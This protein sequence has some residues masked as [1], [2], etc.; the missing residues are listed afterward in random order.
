M[1]ASVL[2]AVEAG[3]PHPCAPLDIAK[4]F[5]SFGRRASNAKSSSQPTSSSQRASSTPAPPKA[6]SKN[7]PEPD[8]EEFFE[9]PKRYWQRIEM[10][11]A[12][13]EAVMVPPISKI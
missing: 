7:L 10:D 1:C 8:Y 3:R 9:M 5:A 12:E 4:G 2:R 11:N 13:I 6:Q